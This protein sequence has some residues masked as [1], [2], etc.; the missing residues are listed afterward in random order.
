MV[1]KVLPI[2]KKL[3]YRKAGEGSFR[4]QCTLCFK[5]QTKVCPEPV[6]YSYSAHFIPDWLL[7]PPSL[8]GV[9]GKRPLDFH[10]IQVIL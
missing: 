9:L 2:K 7:C 3:R 4:E 8:S 1:R 5:E 10:V 6:S